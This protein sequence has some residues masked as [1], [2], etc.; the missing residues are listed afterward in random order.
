[1]SDSS[2]KREDTKDIRAEKGKPREFWIPCAFDENGGENWFEV[3]DKPLKVGDRY[4]SGYD[5]NYMIADK[6]YHAIE[7]SAY[8]QAVKEQDE[9]RVECRAAIVRANGLQDDLTHVQNYSM[10]LFDIIIALKIALITI[11]ELRGKAIINGPI[12]AAYT[13]E[14][15][16]KK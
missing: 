15:F 16:K 12:L 4:Y 2:D 6:V 3:S 1:M 14:R 11:S 10:D 7:Y 8:E 13:I 5:A 9:I